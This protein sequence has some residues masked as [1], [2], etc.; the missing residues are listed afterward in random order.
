MNS[1]GSLLGMVA[2][3]S[4]E[5]SGMTEEHWRKEGCPIPES[6]YNDKSLPP[7]L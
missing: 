5:F 4:I 6:S 2:T 1:M 7:I 3:E